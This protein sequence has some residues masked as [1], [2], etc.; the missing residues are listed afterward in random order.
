MQDVWNRIEAE[1]RRQAPGELAFLS[2]KAT[3]AQIDKLES[4][5]GRPLPDDIRQSYAIH[6]GVRGYLVPSHPGRNSFDLLL[7]LK[8]IAHELKTWR[9]ML[10]GGEFA[11]NKPNPTGPIRRVWWSMGWVPIIGE[12]TGDHLC[13]DLDPPEGGS[14]G[15]VFDFGHEYGPTRVFYPDFGSLMEHY[16][17]DLKSGAVRYNP[18]SKEWSRMEEHAA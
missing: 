18:E 9:G 7:D 17:D 16:A 8:T 1:I 4:L 14:Y 10:E 3:K 5:V 6:N 12:G 15:Q 2:R 13:I 11:G